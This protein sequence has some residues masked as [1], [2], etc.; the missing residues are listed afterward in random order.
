LAG[1]GSGPLLLLAGCSAACGALVV[2]AGASKVYR[3]ARGLGGG[4]GRDSRG[5][6]SAVRRTLRIPLRRWR[7]VEFGVGVLECVVGVVVCAG[8]W[9]VPGGAALATL[10]AAFC[11][12]LG[13]ARVR[14]VP[15]G[16]GC[17]TW[18]SAGGRAGPSVSWFELARSAVLL[19]VGVGGAVLLPGGAGA[20]GA[21]AVRIGAV[22][23]GAAGIGRAWFAGGV[24]LAAAVLVLLS[25][26]PPLRTPACHRPFW[27]PSRATL[28]A[29]TAH[30]VFAAMAESA[31]PFG[32]VARYQRSGCAEEFWF[33]VGGTDTSRAV[34]FRVRY[35]A[36]DG[37]LAVQASRQDG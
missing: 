3:G 23:I 34:V 17:I 14:R 4:Y 27:R 11:V 22:G 19:G 21:G 32:P 1:T 28:R 20:V 31:G 6:D 26:N 33:P 9:P 8:A 37:T 24:L 15:G 18:R 29:L 36:A 10:G 2:L 25:L 12:V 7:R 5:G 30:P 16:C 13:Y 35:A